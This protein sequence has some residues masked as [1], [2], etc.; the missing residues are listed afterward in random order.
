MSFFE[1]KQ[2]KAARKPCRCY[3]CDE[4]IKIGDS[5]TTTATVFEGEFQATKFHPECYDA[6]ELWQELYLGEYEWP[7]MGSMERGSFSEKG[8]H[9]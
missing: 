5:K 3:W 8:E 9:P 4:T 2:I 6:L 1:V 7:E